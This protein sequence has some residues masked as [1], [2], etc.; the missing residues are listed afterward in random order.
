MSRI[1]PRFVVASLAS[2][3]NAIVGASPPNKST[4]NPVAP[5]PPMTLRIC[6]FA[7]SISPAVAAASFIM[8]MFVMPPINPKNCFT[9]LAAF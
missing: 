8:P 5:A 1:A 3:E 6:A 4:A 7:C 9:K 2:G